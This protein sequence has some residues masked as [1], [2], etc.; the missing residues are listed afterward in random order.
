MENYLAMIRRADF[1][2]LFKY[3]SLHVN[4]D[5]TR[6]FTCP[7][8]NLPDMITIFRDLTYY[9][10]VFE[11]SFSYLFIHYTKNIGRCNDIHITEVKHIY[12][13]DYEAKKELS[14]AFDPRIQIEAP[15]WP[16]AVLELQK[17]H[18]RQGCKN[19][20]INIWKIY[21]MD[22]SIEDIE[23]SYIT[24]SVINEVV[25][26]L[27]ANRHPE[28]VLPVWVYAMRYERHAFYPANTIGCFMDAIHVI[29][30]FMQQ[31]ELDAEAIENTNIMQFLQHLN[32]SLEK[33]QFKIILEELSKEE[34][35]VTILEK[36]KEIEP[37]IDL[38]KCLT[39]FFIYRNRYREEFRYEEEWANTG[40]QNSKE[41]SIAAYM[42]GCILQH[43]HTYDCLYEHLPLDIFKKKESSKKGDKAK[44]S[45]N[46]IESKLNKKEQDEIDE[47]PLILPKEE[48]PQQN[49]SFSGNLF[50]IEGT[51]LPEPIVMKKS[52][53][54]RKGIVTVKTEE[55]YRAYL[56]KGYKCYPENIKTKK[57][58]SKK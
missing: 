3:G 55:E 49:T 6:Q 28:G 20:A 43:E 41:F 46:I 40:K 14:H 23:N 9:A 11:S 26:E 44:P 36:A 19:G 58:N 32:N 22:G 16:N 30:N 17:E 50:E 52:P 1:I 47:I 15:L 24:S 56:D 25:D 39:L 8:E 5:L 2:D 45:N 34:S 21:G 54:A 31:Q 35:V 38:I 53:N 12:P 37:T 42:L 27:Y 33:V 7:V 10:N 4:K 57:R 51:P 48:Y 29:F 13:L 18:S